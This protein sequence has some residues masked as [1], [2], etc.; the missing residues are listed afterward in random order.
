MFPSLLPGVAA[1]LQ[2]VRR[3]G[4]QDDQ[5]DQEPPRGLRLHR[6]LGAAASIAPVANG[7][8]GGRQLRHD[9][10]GAAGSLRRREW[11]WRNAPLLLGEEPNHQCCFFLG[12]KCPTGRSSRFI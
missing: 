6:L 2:R 12:T 11:R 10:D 5:P 8:D 4:P 9:G 3:R 1:P 7:R